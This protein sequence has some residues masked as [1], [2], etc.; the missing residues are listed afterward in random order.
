M[1]K[2]DGE[3]LGLNRIKLGFGKS[4]PTNCVWLHGVSETL[5]EKSLIRQCTR[6]GAVVN[7]TI[8]RER[9]NALVCYDTLECAQIAVSDLKGRLLNGRRL[10][11]DFASR[12]CQN[13]FF[14]KLELSGQA[15]PPDRP[16]ERRTP[17]N[18]PN[19]NWNEVEERGA[20]YEPHNNRNYIRY[21]NQPRNS[22]RNPFRGP[23]SPPPPPVSQRSQPAYTGKGRGFRY[24]DGFNERRHRVYEGDE[25]SQE[26]EDGF[27]DDVREFNYSRDRSRDFSETRGRSYSPLR[28]HCEGTESPSKDRLR[29]EK[30]VSPFPIDGNIRENNDEHSTKER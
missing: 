13:A 23:Q 28:V 19:N 7:L 22:N 12:E 2:L 5:S 4:M 17:T 11:V 10:Q 8:D 24:Q 6:F 9:G 3:N 1:R 14:E 26:S 30:S 15:V 27:V 25:F 16:W 18:T 21:E 20:L 29:E